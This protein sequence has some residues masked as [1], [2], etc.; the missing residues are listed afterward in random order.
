MRN[1]FNDTSYIRTM[2]YDTVYSIFTCMD[3]KNI[4]DPYLD[5]RINYKDNNEIRYDLNSLYRILNA[6]F[7]MLG[8]KP[9]YWL[10]LH[11]D[12]IIQIISLY[13]LQKYAEYAINDGEYV[14]TFDEK[15]FV[16]FI[17]FEKHNNYRAGLGYFDPMYVYNAKPKEDYGC[18]ENDVYPELNV[19]DL[20]IILIHIDNDGFSKNA[21]FICR[22]DE[23]DDT[24][25]ANYFDFVQ[26]NCR[27]LE[28]AAMVVAPG[29][30]ITIKRGRKR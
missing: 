17:N 25:I 11:R 13:L 14:L 18:D 1:T 19:F 5:I 26:R 16:K 3:N 29:S 12:E 21:L 24:V 10:N 2:T 22:K 7:R 15:D 23:D 4:N 20:D 9:Q 27:E 6:D 8:S 30:T 28:I